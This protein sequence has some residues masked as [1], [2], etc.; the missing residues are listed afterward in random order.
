MNP[1]F[2][3]KKELH[4][5]AGVR[6]YIAILLLEAEIHC[7]CSV[8]RVDELRQPTFTGVFR[9][10]VIPDLWRD[11][12]ALGKFDLGRLSHTLQRGL[13]LAEHAAFVKTLAARSS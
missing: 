12:P 5:S 13:R 3:V 9:C 2:G 7:H 11:G 8:K 10:R 4:Q 6:Q 1:G